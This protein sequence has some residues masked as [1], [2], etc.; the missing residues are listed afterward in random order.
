[1]ET[2][3]HVL[4]WRRR[5]GMARL[6]QSSAGRQPQPPLSGIVPALACGRAASKGKWGREA[7]HA[8]TMLAAALVQEQRRRTL[9]YGLPMLAFTVVAARRTP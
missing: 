5:Q 8:F 6:G 1:M 3:Y 9:F 2:E 4:L 7:S